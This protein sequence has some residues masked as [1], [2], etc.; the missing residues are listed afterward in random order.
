MMRRIS[1]FSLLTLCCMFVISPITTYG[2]SIQTPGYVRGKV[3]EVKDGNSFVLQG[4]DHKK[5]N[6]KIAGIETPDDDYVYD[7]LNSYLSGKNVKV[8][9][10][11]IPSTNLKPFSYGVVYYDDVNVGRTM[12]TSGLVKLDTD[13]LN[14]NALK[15]KYYGYQNNAIR[16]HDGIWS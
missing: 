5:Y 8:N 2:E 9:I 15:N 6:I 10:L 4:M 3:I 11:P 7:F 12:L 13:S 16:G 14:S 1:L